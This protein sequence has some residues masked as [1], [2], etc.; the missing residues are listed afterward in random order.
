MLDFLKRHSP[1]NEPIGNRTPRHSSFQR[2][3]VK[4]I[5]CLLAGVMLWAPASMFTAISCGIDCNAM[6]EP[7]SVSLGCIELPA[8]TCLNGDTG[9]PCV[10][11][12]GCYC[13]PITDPKVGC[14]VSAC[15]GAAD[16]TACAA[17][18]GCEW[19]DTCRNLIDCHSLDSQSAC[20]ANDH[21]C[22]WSKD[23]CG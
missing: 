22:Y 15:A 23:G 8:A 10:R 19:G 6:C 1:R 16:Q 17:T 3:R 18:I 12:T 11:A 14:N 4:I 2:N 7:R 21:Q 20:N 5:R 13:G 9:Y